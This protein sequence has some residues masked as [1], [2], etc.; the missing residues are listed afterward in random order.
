MFY[1]MGAA[2][3]ER[4]QFRAYSNAPTEEAPIDFA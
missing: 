1:C 3:I 2:L 4:I